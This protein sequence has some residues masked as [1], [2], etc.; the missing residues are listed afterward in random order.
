M[1]IVHSSLTRNGTE[2]VVKG[3]KKE[4]RRGIG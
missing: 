1:S 4:E 2:K 3:E